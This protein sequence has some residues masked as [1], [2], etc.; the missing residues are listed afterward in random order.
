[1]VIVA[2]LGKN[3]GVLEIIVAAVV[4]LVSATYMV[5][6]DG[7]HK[8]CLVRDMCLVRIDAVGTVSGSVCGI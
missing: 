6:F 1:M 5:K 2:V 7:I 4:A 3:I 8:R